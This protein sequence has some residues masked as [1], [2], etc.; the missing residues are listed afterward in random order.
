M[1]KP[2]RRWTLPQWSLSCFKALQK[3]EQ[4][5]ASHRIDSIWKEVKKQK[6]LEQTLQR[7]YGDLVPE[8]EKMQQAQKQEEIAAKNHA[9]E[10]SKAAEDQTVVQSVVTD[11]PIPLQKSSLEALFLVDHL[12]MKMQASKWMLKKSILL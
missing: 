11:E 5:A 1:G 6:E 4:L 12:M 7:R 2:S 8:L 10:L 3:Q 9:L